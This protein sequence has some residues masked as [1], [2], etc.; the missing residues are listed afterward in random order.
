MEGEDGSM[1]AVRRIDD[2][3]CRAMNLVHDD[4]FVVAEKSLSFAL[5]FLCD[6]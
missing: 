1:V 4:V 5:L 2:C 3:C 6:L